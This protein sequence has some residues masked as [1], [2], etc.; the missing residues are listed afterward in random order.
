MQNLRAFFKII[1]VFIILFLGISILALLMPFTSRK[2]AHAIFMLLKG[3]LLRAVG[4]KVHG[5]KMERIGPGL[6]MANHR[7]Y[8]DILFIP[9]TELFTIV[10]K[11]EVRSWPVIGFAGR[12]LGV[13]WVNRESKESRSQ[14]KQ[15]IV[16]AIHSGQ[17]VVIFPEGSS[18]EGPFLLPLKPG[19]F[20]E[21]AKHKFNIYQWSLHFDDAVTGFPFGVGFLNHLWAVCK[22]TSINAYI[23]VREV[24]VASSSGS[25][26]I[27]DCTAWWNESL[28]KLSEK[29]PARNSGYW[30][31]ARID[32]PS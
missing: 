13:L 12:A 27:E 22:E 7:S 5:P 14:T 25:E 18:W 15:N 10:G 30:P 29:Y 8:L 21:S 26:L 31:D 16:N 4:V 1:L 9:T 19:M 6:I 20:H 2:T 11:I 3:S 24:P 17:T 28:T 32:L 23:D